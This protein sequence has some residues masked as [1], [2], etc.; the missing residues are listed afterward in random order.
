MSVI[1]SSK[2]DCGCMHTEGDQGFMHLKVLPAPNL[3]SHENL[4]EVQALAAEVQDHFCGHL[5]NLPTNSFMKSNHAHF[6]TGKVQHE[7][8]D[9]MRQSG[10]TMRVEHASLDDNIVCA[11]VT[12]DALMDVLRDGAVTVEAPM[13]KGVFRLHSAESGHLTGIEFIPHAD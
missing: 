7:L 10:L 8:P 11:E 6:T 12:H 13:N 3:H 9:I 2:H 1:K 5:Q 4:A